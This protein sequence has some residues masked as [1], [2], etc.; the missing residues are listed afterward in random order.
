MLKNENHPSWKAS[1]ALRS[2]GSSNCKLCENK[3]RGII[4][5]QE[6][7]RLFLKSIRDHIGTL[8]PAEKF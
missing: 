5:T 7:V 2:R 4:W 1:V 6:T 8:T 3:T